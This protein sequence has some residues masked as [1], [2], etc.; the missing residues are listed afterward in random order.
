MKKYIWLL[1][2]GMLLFT[3][4]GSDD[5][6]NKKDDTLTPQKLAGLWAADYAENKTDGDLTWTRVVADYLFR[7][8]GTGYYECFLLDGDNYVG[9]ESARGEDGEGDFHYTISGNTVTVTIDKTGE[10]WTMTYADGK[11]SDPERIAFQKATTAQ[12]TLVEQLYGE[13]QKAN[14]GTK[15]D[16]TTVKTDVTD[17][18]TDEPARARRH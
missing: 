14:S 17:G 15:D 9:A 6:G 12:Q 18:Y 10:K 16:G 11:L 3:A 1:T 8:D 7:A 13:W 5:D 2:V 4:C